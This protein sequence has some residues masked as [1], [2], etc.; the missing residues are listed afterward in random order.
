[1]KIFNCDKSIINGIKTLNLLDGICLIVGF[2]LGV[3]VLNEY[4]Y[5]RIFAN[6]EYMLIVL[7]LVLLLGYDLVKIIFR[8]IISGNLE[9][10]RLEITDNGLNMLFYEKLYS[11]E[12]VKY[13]EVLWSDVK[14]AEAVDRKVSFRW[15]DIFKVSA[16]R[17]EYRTINIYTKNG[18][19]RLCIE[20][21]FDAIAF[22]NGKAGSDTVNPNNAQEDTKPEPQDAQNSKEIKMPVDF[23]RCANCGEINDSDITICKCGGKRR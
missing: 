17:E 20:N 18:L 6:T 10:E 7:F 19:Y 2:V 14:Y 9:K 11:S 5:L 3:I 15:V 12:S 22:I 16:Y 1:M 4:S 23:W 21:V 13:A 8:F